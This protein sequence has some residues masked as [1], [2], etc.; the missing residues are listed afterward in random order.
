MPQTN[1]PGLDLAAPLTQARSLAQDLLALLPNLALAAVTLLIAYVAARLSARLV[2]A[3]VRRANGNP[4]AGLLLGRLARGGVLMV[5]VLVA[6]STVFP[7][8]QARD[9]IQLL[10]ISGV[11]VG[12][13]FKD[14][15]Q[16]FLAGVIILISRP[17]RIGD[18][19]AVKS[20]EGI[21][22]DIQTRAT[23]IRTA[24]NQRVVVPNT[25]LFSEEVKVLTAYDTRRTEVEMGIGYARDLEAARA[26]VLAV[27]PSV[28]GVLPSPAPDVLVT[29]FTDTR[30]T[31]RVR[32]W[33]RS[34]ANLVVLRDEVARAAR[35]AMAEAGVPLT[36]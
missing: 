7:S 23:M 22:E 25:V 28:A 17:F 12:F 18:T 13:A 35:T 19:I 6:L 14:I 30:A 9:L 10:G 29:G 31:L 24:D 34:D 27:L 26:S 3:V 2:H 16:N 20:Y 11:A 21:V 36:A 8:F 15:F 33:T 5:G 4:T 32:V 1:P